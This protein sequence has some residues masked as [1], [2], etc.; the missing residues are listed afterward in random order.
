[1]IAPAGRDRVEALAEGVAGCLPCS[2][3]PPQVA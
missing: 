1:M 2:V 3:A